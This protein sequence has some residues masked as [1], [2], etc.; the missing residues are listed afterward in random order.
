VLLIRI[1]T[2]L[3]G[4]IRIRT[5]SDRCE[6]YSII[7]SWTVHGGQSHFQYQKSVEIFF[8]L[9]SWKVSTYR[10]LFL[11]TLYDSVP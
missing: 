8:I 6:A 1:R 2:E 3:K 10:E 11:Q 5:K 4:R 9:V 7:S